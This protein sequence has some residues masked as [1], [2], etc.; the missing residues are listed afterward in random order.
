MSMALLKLDHALI[1]LK[2]TLKHDSLVVSNCTFVL[3]H[4]LE[5]VSLKLLSLI[6]GFLFGFLLVSFLL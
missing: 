6:L 1:W 5:G 4:H 3:L 2:I